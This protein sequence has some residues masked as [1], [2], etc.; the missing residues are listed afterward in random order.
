MIKFG[1]RVLL[2]QVEFVIVWHLLRRKPVIAFS[3]IR[4]HLGLVCNYVL[5]SLI[6]VGSGSNFSLELERFPGNFRCCHLF[7]ACLFI[8]GA[9]RKILFAYFFKL[10]GACPVR[11]PLLLLRT[12]GFRKLLW[13]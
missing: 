9:R 11:G 12:D 5:R 10:P 3:I 4:L 1:R 6:K 13:V 8:A 2:S 7:G